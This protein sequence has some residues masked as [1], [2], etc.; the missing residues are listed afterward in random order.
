MCLSFGT[1]RLHGSLLAANSFVANTGTFVRDTH[2]FDSLCDSVI[3]HL[4][5]KS[6]AVQQAVMQLIATLAA[7]GPAKFL[8]YETKDR[9][10][11]RWVGGC[12][13]REGV[14]V[15]EQEQETECNFIIM[16]S[17]FFFSSFC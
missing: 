4:G 5:S 11:R 12:E 17:F 9:S 14:G 6:L 7:A 10:G 2:Y 1:D 8:S 16:S 13:G 3:K 15:Q